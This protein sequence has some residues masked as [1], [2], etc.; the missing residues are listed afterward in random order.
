[1]TRTSLLV[2][3][4]VIVAVTSPAAGQQPPDDSDPIARHLF[5]PD[6]IMAHQEKLGLQEK[7]RAAIKAEVLKAQPKFMERQWEMGE[8][9]QKMVALL[10]AT[11][12]DEQ[13][14]LEQADRIMSLERSVKRMHLS[15]LIRLKNILSS[16]QAA[17]L[18]QIR[19]R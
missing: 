12:I 5:P 19:R 9:T 4:L 2:I 18:D 16:E 7:Q 11:P 3:A 6:L 1:M 17:R 15:L 10:R 8:E 14:V 13:K